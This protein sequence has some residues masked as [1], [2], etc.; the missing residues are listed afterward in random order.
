MAL[1]DQFP[2]RTLAVADTMDLWIDT[3]RPAL[4]ELL[5]KVDGLVLNNDEAEQ[6]TGERNLVRAAERIVELGPKFVVV[7]KGE[8]GALIEH[9]G[10]KVVLPAFPTAYVI[11][12]TGAGDCFA[13]GFMGYLAASGRLDLAAMRTAM[14]YGTIV[15]SFNIESFSLDRLQQIT[16]ADVDERFEG[17]RAMMAVGG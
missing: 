3:Q 11:D 4:L 12:P 9:G 14:A 17:Y 13:G 8:H 10:V 7:K 5:G 6:L 15:A 1:L 2:D 16:R